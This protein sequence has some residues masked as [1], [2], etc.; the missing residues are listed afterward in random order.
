MVAICVLLELQITWLV[1]LIVAPDE[2]SPMA[3]NWLVSFGEETDWD[4]GMTEIEAI[5]PPATPPL[6][7][8]T[9]RVA[10][11][12]VG[13]LNAAAPAVIVVVPGPTAVT[14]P[15]SLIVATE[16]ALE[17]H[18]TPLVIFRVEG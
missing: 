9:V 14:I 11:E 16:G 18:V 1:R 8:V 6:E 5:V 3:R 7:P 12:L 4:P 13:P 10:L 17:V 2:V 15:E